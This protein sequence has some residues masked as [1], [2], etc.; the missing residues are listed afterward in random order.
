[1]L[2][3]SLSLRSLAVRLLPLALAAGSLA[4]CQT[5]F[6]A[7][8]AVVIYDRSRMDDA[9][10]TA[11]ILSRQGVRV[12]LQVR[13][14]LPRK[15]STIAVYDAF[16]NPDRAESVA[17]LLAPI[18]TFN[19]LQFPEPNGQTDIV[20]WLEVPAAEIQPDPQEPEPT[21]DAR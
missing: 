14:P 5:T 13:G 15:E 16:R 2:N 4:G 3:T 20:V 17:N 9:Q 18:G 1:M 21:P 6:L 19:L 10:K 12:D 7:E 11:Q 8:R